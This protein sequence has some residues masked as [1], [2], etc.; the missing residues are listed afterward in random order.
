MKYD[1]PEKLREIA[2]VFSSHS[3]CLYLVGGAVRDF[4]LGRKN[5]DYDLTTSATPE[6]VKAMFRRTIDTGIK[7]GTVTVIYR[8][9]H[10]EITTFRTEGD[11]TDSRHPDSVTFVRSLE[12]DLKRRDFTINALAVDILT[13]D[14]IDMH[15]GREDLE[16]GIIRAIGNAEERFGED[17]LRMMRACRFSSKLGFTIEEKTLSAIKDLHSSIRKVSVERI[18]E[19][20]DKLL[21][22][23]FPVQGLMYLRDTGLLGKIIPELT[24]TAGILSA[25][26]KAE[27]AK[28]PLSAFYAILFSDLDS[29]TA[30]EILTRLRSSNREKEDV[31]H[32]VREW[33]YDESRNTPLDA[34][35]F[36]HE[37]GR[38][39]IPLIFAVRKALR[40]FTGDDGK[41]ESAVNREIENKSP[42]FI[43]D[44]AITGSDLK[45]VVPPGPAMGKAL[46]YLLEKVIENPGYNT[47]EKLLE[48]IREA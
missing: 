17:A 26:E 39:L 33:K 11:Y 22:S 13:G 18:K 45:T 20:L 10:Y 36:I 15:G 24:L 27:S 5:D 28:L 1:A 37:N 16:N 46:S 29:G 12:E 4:L 32:I 21:L 38:E 31:C 43:K 47:K 41:F 30:S 19:E 2:Q 23:R 7:H 6:E 35:L 14:I 25:M 34:R 40:D 48:I 9:E 8:G 42:V 44:L 3:Y